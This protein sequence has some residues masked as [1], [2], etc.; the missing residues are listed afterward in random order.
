MFVNAFVAADSQA[1]QHKSDSR[2]DS[3]ENTYAASD[4]DRSTVL[5]V[6]EADT[7]E[8]ETEFPGMLDTLVSEDSG[9]NSPTYS[10]HAES[11][12]I[13][14]SGDTVVTDRSQST[15]PM[16]KFN[17]SPLLNSDAFSNDTDDSITPTGTETI[18]SVVS[19]I[20]TVD[21]PRE[22][23]SCL[24][25]PAAALL[26]ARAP[27]LDTESLS[28][29]PS[30]PKVFQSAFTDQL[31]GQV[32]PKAQSM[33]NEPLS[34]VSLH[35]VTSPSQQQ[36]PLQKSKS[37]ASVS[38]LIHDK[39]QETFKPVITTSMT[40][41]SKGLTKGLFHFSKKKAASTS[42]LSGLNT[43]SVTKSRGLGFTKRLSARRQIIV[44][45]DSDLDEDDFDG[46]E[47]DIDAV[48]GGSRYA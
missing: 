27:L 36:L 40:K 24:T 11:E 32:L 10:F 21:I 31:T 48:L 15:P 25:P 41:A 29:V 1:S 30:R 20:K 45:D 35:P 3:N 34:Y 16:Q 14:V 26:M 47:V 18:P 43:K 39:D 37:S 38:H 33:F 19:N 46:N 22:L 44:D 13:S 6:D 9:M 8:Y 4:R 23:D 2:L 12:S 7:M 5:I 28:P 17:F 42:D